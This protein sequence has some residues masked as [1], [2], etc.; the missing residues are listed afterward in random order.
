MHIF[1][2]HCFPE[3]C[4]TFSVLYCRGA[5]SEV[6]FGLTVQSVVCPGVRFL[7]S[8]LLHGEP[9]VF[10]GALSV[11]IFLRLVMMVLLQ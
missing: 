2:S 7:C 1:Q 5:G 4:G 10:P 11:G 8:V 9:F 6:C 3:T